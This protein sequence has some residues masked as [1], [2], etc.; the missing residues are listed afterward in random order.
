MRTGFHLTAVFLLLGLLFVLSPHDRGLHAQSINAVSQFAW[1]DRSGK[2]LGTFGELADYLG[3]ELSH[4]GKRLAVPFLDP[5]RG[6]HDIWV[7]DVASGRRTQLTSDPGDENFLIWSPDDRRVVF[8][9][10]RN[11]GGRSLDLF[12][13]SSAGGGPEEVL[14]A[15][16]VAKWPVSWSPDGRNILYVTSPGTGD[17]PNNDIWVLPLFGDRKPYPLLATP[18]TE[19]WPAF[20][21]DGKWI[22]YSSTESG[23]LELYVMQFP[24]TGNKWQV[25]SGGGFQARWR[26]DGKELFYLTENRTLMAATVNASGSGFEVRDRQMLFETKFAH[27]QYH[28]YDVAADGQRVLINTAVLL[29]SGPATNARLLSDRPFELAHLFTRRPN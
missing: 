3:M 8:N 29:P 12:Q 6:T 20:S 24:P 27:G 21:P 26:R 13:A 1:F 15:D 23:A 14:L 4:D 28:A 25:S 10:T 16:L 7:F 11:R 9:S 22:A 5:S 2:R 18:A 19:N 17:I